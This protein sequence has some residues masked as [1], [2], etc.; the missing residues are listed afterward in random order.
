M[1]NP[2][3]NIGRV[4]GEPV[5]LLLPNVNGKMDNDKIGMKKEEWTSMDQVR[6]PIEMDQ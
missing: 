1:N 4:N 2:V 3:T 6:V 5:Q